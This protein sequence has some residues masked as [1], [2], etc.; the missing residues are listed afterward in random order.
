MS[1]RTLRL[2]LIVAFRLF[3]GNS[4]YRTDRRT[5]AAAYA[6]IGVDNPFTAFFADCA[7]WTLAIAGSAIDARIGNFISHNRL[8]IS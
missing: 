8:L 1:L 5:C 3:L 4:F 2:P 7:N 6:G